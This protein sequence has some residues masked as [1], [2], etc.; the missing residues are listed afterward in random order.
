MNFLSVGGGGPNEWHPAIHRGVLPRGSYG[1]STAALDWVAG[2]ARARHDFA[3]VLS[4][5]GAGAACQR[6]RAAAHVLSTVRVPRVRRRRRQHL[7]PPRG[8][9]HH[10][11]TLARD[12]RG[13]LQPPRTIERG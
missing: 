3:L 10:T 9:R 1:C 11:A 12:Q 6:P 4:R 5:H 13:V 2:A 8:S 7:R